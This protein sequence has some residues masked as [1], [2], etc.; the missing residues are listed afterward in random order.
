MNVNRTIVNDIDAIT[1]HC[2][3]HALVRPMLRVGLQSLKK[4]AIVNHFTSFRAAL[5]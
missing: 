1:S 5:A 3:V 2:P 4:F